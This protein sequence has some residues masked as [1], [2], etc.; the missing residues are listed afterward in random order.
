MAQYYSKQMIANNAGLNDQFMNKVLIHRQDINRI[1]RQLYGN[2]DSPL[3]NPSIDAWRSMD[4]QIKTAY[5]EFND[6]LYNLLKP[7]ER[8][9]NIGKIVDVAGTYSGDIPVQSSLDGQEDR[10]LGT[11]GIEWSGVA[12]PTHKANV[13]IQ[14]RVAEG[15]RDKGF[16]DFLRQQNFAIFRVQERA[17][18]NYVNGTDK[19]FQGYK[20]FGLKNNPNT[21]GLDLTSSDLSVNLTD[22]TQTVKE[23]VNAFK[24]VVN[25]FFNQRNG[26]GINGKVTLFVSTEVDETINSIFNEDGTRT[27][28]SVIMQDSRIQDIVSHYTLQGNEMFGIIPSRLYVEPII[29]LATTTYLQ[30]RWSRVQAFHAEV[31]NVSGLQVYNQGGVS[32]VFY[33]KG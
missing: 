33:A 18:D 16:D 5:E 31:L 32:G 17:L 19:T 28:R 7:L 14:W 12:I 24:A 3:L 9:V 4:R 27:I 10:I 26:L 2:A 13:G 8:N 29:G 15:L 20:A 11:T 21:L 1:E 25:K 22:N 6:P 23:Y 30:P